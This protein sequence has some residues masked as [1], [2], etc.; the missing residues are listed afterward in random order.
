MPTGEFQ[1]F[2]CDTV[3]YALGT[4]ANPIITQSTP[5]LALNKWGNIVADDATHR[6]GYLMSYLGG[7]G[8]PSPRGASAARAAGTL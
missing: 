5:G 6:Y 8:V 7:R 4:K 3:I 1:T 2:E